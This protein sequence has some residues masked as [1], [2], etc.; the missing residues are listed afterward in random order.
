MSCRHAFSVSLASNYILFENPKL[1]SP[2]KRIYVAVAAGSLV[3]LWR[4]DGSASHVPEEQFQELGNIAGLLDLA[5][6][7]P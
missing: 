7:E 5:R 4:C 2:R 6:L 3:R 1:A